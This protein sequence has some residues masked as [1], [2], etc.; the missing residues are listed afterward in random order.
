[1]IL[2]IIL[3][4]GVLTTVVSYISTVLVLDTSLLVMAVKILNVQRVT[5]LVVAQLGRGS[6]FKSLVLGS[7]SSLSV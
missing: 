5:S 1:M 6:W 2:L 7:S 4:L 3:I